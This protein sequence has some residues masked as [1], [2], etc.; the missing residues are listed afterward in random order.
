ML[1]AKV[2][3]PKPE[4]LVPVVFLIKELKP[5]PVLSEPV[6]TAKAE[7]PTLVLLV[8]AARPTVL[9]AVVTK[10]VVAS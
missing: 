5:K 7:S 4:L 3:L 10:A 2:E 8:P 6:V 9:T 1:D